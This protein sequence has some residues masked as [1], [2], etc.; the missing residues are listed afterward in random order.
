MKSTV[1]KLFIV[2]LL[3]I[4]SIN[5]QAGFIDIMGVNKQIDTLEY[6]IIGPGIEYIRLYLPEYPIAAYL[7]VVDLNNPYNFIETF[8]AQNHLGKTEAMTSAYTRLDAENHRTIA[9]V[10]GN[11]WVVSPQNPPPE[12]LGQPHS[13][14]ILNGEILTEPNDWNRF[15]STPEERAQ[16]IGF[17]LMDKTKKLMV[18]DLYFSGKV[19]IEDGSEYQISNV[20]RM[21]Y[22]NQLVFYNSYL[23]IGSTTHTDDS[24][25]EV[26]IKLSDKDKWDVNEDIEC[27]VSRIIKDKGKNTLEEGEV[28]LSGH[29]YARDFLEK[30]SIGDKLIVN[31][32]IFTRLKNEA[33]AVDQLITGNA[34]VAIDGELTWRNYR[35]AYNNQLYPR[36]G[37]GSSK[38]GKTL[39]MIVIDK[40][41]GSVGASTE[42]MCEILKHYGA[43]NISSM[44]G[45]GSAQMMIEGNIVNKPA[46]GKERPVA[47]GW[48]LFHNTPNDTQ[49]TNLMFYDFKLEIPSY[50]SYRPTILGYNQYGVLIDQNVQNYTLSCSPEIG[51]ISPEG[52]FIAGS[53]E[54]TGVLTASFNGITVSKEIKIIK[55]NLSLKNKSILI[56]GKREYPIEVLSTVGEKTLNVAPSTLFWEIENPA[57]CELNNGVLKGLANGNTKIKGKIADFEDEFSVTVEIP[58]S[59][60]FISDKFLTSEWILSSANQLSAQLNTENLPANWEHGAAVNFVY[61]AGRAPFIKMTNQKALYSLPDTIKFTIN[62]GAVPIDRLILNF[63]TNKSSSLTFKEYN[64]IP[65]NQD[66]EIAIAFDELFD[67]KDIA[68]YP[69]YFDNINI[70]LKTPNDGMSHTIAYKDIVLCYKEKNMT[71]V[72]VTNKDDFSIYPNPIDGDVIYLHFPNGAQKTN[73]SIYSLTGQVIKSY[74]IAGT[75]DGENVQLSLPELKKGLYLLHIKNEN[76]ESS[77]KI[78]KK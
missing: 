42:T 5:S 37:I 23:G 10:N 4:K 60:E 57:I 28:V 64:A 46:D 71:S 48:F 69:I 45:G 21:R 25:I 49:L 3:L 54:S 2:L 18:D 16:E 63:R 35:E 70:Y 67:T 78:I 15:G 36:T 55:A 7:M 31:M 26:F 34:L 22:D 17:V 14:A 9:G 29:G 20:N 51:E 39:Y 41:A 12:L 33:I 68:I 73:C 47:N 38:D 11:F 40:G 77:I 1:L 58:E 66:F 43:S 30:L 44:D 61:K 27:E 50:S 62:A 65:Q 6:R 13:G 76:L 72:S 59:C 56:D 24:G 52:L 8:Q 53:T 32:G 75:H 19:K 74:H